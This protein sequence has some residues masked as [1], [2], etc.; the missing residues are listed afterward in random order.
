MMPPIGEPFTVLQS[1][2]STN[3]YAMAQVHAGLASHGNAYFAMEQTG[4]K[5][6]RGKTWNTSVGENIALSIVLKPGVLILSDQFLLSLAVALACYD[7]ISQYAG[8]ETSIKWPNDI[9]WRDRKAGGILIENVIQGVNWQYAIVG[10]GIN[11][12]QTRFDQNLKNPVSL[13][14]I[15]GNTIDII[16]LSKE[17]CRALQYRFDALQTRDVSLLEQYNNVLY[18]REQTVTLKHKNIVFK[19]VVKG[20]NRQGRLI[21]QA[22]IEQQYDWGEIE[23]L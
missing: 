22:G 9:Y 17:L 18:K 21:V 15:T 14:Q 23:W 19:T 8:E 1:I 11:I 7:L 2:D 16:E 10:I 4:G 20:V 5:G 6:Q 3:N 13:K 12:N